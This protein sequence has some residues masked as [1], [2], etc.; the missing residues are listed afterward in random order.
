MESVLA[1]AHLDIS[2]LKFMGADGIGLSLSNFM[3]RLS[4]FMDFS[5]DITLVYNRQSDIVAFAISRLGNTFESMGSRRFHLVGDI[6]KCLKAA[7]DYVLDE[8]LSML[9]SVNGGIKKKLK[10]TYLKVDK[11]KIES[12]LKDLKLNYDKISEHIQEIK[13]ML[14]W[15]IDDVSIKPLI[16]AC[17]YF[18]CRSNM[19]PPQPHIASNMGPLGGSYH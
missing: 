9:K 1:F 6:I 11:R 13:Q 8:S 5:D 12:S 17:A 15:D 14:S 2:T 18:Q 4:D 19:D 7:K 3:S 10:A 16:Y